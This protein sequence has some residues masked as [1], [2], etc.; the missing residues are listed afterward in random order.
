MAAQNTGVVE[1]SAN[2]IQVMA[3]SSQAYQGFV[4]AYLQKPNKYD[5]IESITGFAA[6][7]DWYVF[8]MA[9]E[10]GQEAAID[11]YFNQKDGSYTA[12]QNGTDGQTQFRYSV[13]SNLIVSSTNLEDVAAGVSNLSYGNLNTAALA[14][15]KTAADQQIASSGQ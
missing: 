2:Y 12:A 15:L 7:R 11:V 5:V 9:D 4:M 14:I 6:C 1:S 8:S 3:S 13:K 10:A